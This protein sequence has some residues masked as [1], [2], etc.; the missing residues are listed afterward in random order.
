MDEVVRNLRLKAPGALGGLAR[1]FQRVSFQV[2]PDAPAAEIARLAARFGT[3]APIIAAAIAAE[4]D[5][6]CTGDRRLRARI[7]EMG[8]LQAVSPAELVD[9]LP[10]SAQ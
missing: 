5:Y 2:A 8:S 3:D 9:L 4:V 6:F 1:I 10:P 7:V